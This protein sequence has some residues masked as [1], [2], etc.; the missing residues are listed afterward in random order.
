MLYARLAKRVWDYSDDMNVFSEVGF[1]WPR[2]RHGMQLVLARFPHSKNMAN[3]FCVFAW[4]ADDHA[5]AH[6][7]FN[8]LG[9]RYME[10]PWASYADFQK[11]QAWAK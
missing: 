5:T 7:L 10:Y 4:Q 9:D 1:S 6:V 11:A 2:V 8:Y 3:E